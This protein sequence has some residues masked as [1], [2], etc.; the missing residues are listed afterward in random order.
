[1]EE[2]ITP[3]KRRWGLWGTI[4]VLTVLGIIG[5]ANAGSNT[6]QT[7]P[8]SSAAAAVEASQQPA[9][10]TPSVVTPAPT[11]SDS[12]VQSSQQ[13]PATTETGLS[14]DNYYTNS[15]GNLV[16]S[17]AYSNDNAAPAGATAQCGDGTYSFS[18]HRSGTC[19]H[20]GGVVSWL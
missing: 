6:Q 18:Q 9:A 14:N 13:A 16:H 8:T 15:S 20:H 7:P 4:G 12:Q 19:S 5:V 1:V 11:A 3:K 10:V 17:P 2:Q